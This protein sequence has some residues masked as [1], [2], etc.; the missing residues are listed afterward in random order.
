M[1]AHADVRDGFI[2]HPLV[3]I[4]HVGSDLA[5]DEVGGGLADSEIFYGVEKSHTALVQ[6]ALDAAI[7]CV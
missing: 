2:A 6:S 7:E 5:D 1:Q 3:G 4:D